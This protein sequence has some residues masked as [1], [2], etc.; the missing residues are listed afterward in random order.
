V[1]QL[2]GGPL[3][4]DRHLEVGGLRATITAC[5]LKISGD[6]DIV[7]LLH[8]SCEGGNDRCRFSDLEGVA[9]GMK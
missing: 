2:E 5:F 1:P 8:P 7:L 9:P 3:L 6:A 4:A